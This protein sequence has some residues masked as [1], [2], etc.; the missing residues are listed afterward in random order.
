M[1][2]LLFPRPPSPFQQ[3]SN[4]ILTRHALCS[5]KRLNCSADN[6]RG[7]MEEMAKAWKIDGWI[8]YVVLFTLIISYLIVIG[9]AACCA[10]MS[11][12][13]EEL[14]LVIIPLT[15]QLTTVANL[16]NFSLAYI[17]GAISSLPLFFLFN[18]KRF[19]RAGSKE[20]L[21]RR[22]RKARKVVTIY[23]TYF[24]LRC[25]FRSNYYFNTRRA[26]KDKKNEWRQIHESSKAAPKGD[27]NLR[28]QSHDIYLCHLSSFCLSTFGFEPA[29]M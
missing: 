26:R 18:P 22:I 4:I 14:D 10:R 13:F 27:N 19:R 15:Y 11:T 29:G 7:F 9:C 25:H 21:R 24:M 20:R 16:K 1:N 17:R 6:A 12:V 2:I 5:F 23:S 8:Y 3:A 28:P